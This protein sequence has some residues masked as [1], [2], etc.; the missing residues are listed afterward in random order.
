M[1]IYNLGKYHL[2][3]KYFIKIDIATIFIV[4]NKNVKIWHCFRTPKFGVTSFFMDCLG[5]KRYLPKLYDQKLVR[6]QNM[7]PQ[8]QVEKF[9]TPNRAGAAHT[10][11]GVLV[12]AQFW[13]PNTFYWELS[14]HISRAIVPGGP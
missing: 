1:F 13:L 7:G 4:L 3:P 5:N 14:A 11:F 10:N 6:P 9:W 12:P 2:F 8:F